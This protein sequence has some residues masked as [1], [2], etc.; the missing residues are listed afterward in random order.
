MTQRSLIAF[1]LSLL[2]GLW[3]L[4][5]GRMMYGGFGRM[6]IHDGRGMGHMMW[7][8]GMMGQFGLWWPWVGLLAGAIVI[9]SAIMLYFAPQY[10]RSLGTTILVAS[11]LNLF[12]GMGGV[13]A[14]ALG[15]AGGIITLTPKA[16][17]QE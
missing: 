1:I 17:S 2:G 10:R 11:I 3:M 16:T 14:S 9:V 13:L 4:T 7:G 5:S 12:L 15:I 6:P 8:R